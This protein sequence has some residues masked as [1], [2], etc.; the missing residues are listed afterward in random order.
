MKSSDQWKGTAASF[1]V[2]SM[3]AIK[4]FQD[5][6]TEFWQMTLFLNTFIMV[7]TLS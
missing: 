2:C 6:A 7:F 5:P 4:T 1:N 3:D